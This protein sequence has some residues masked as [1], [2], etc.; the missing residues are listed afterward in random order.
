MSNTYLEYVNT[1][2][3]DKNF[4]VEF[5]D[6]ANRPDFGKVVARNK[7]AV[8]EIG[9]SGTNW[10]SPSDY[11]PHDTEKFVQLENI[12]AARLYFDYDKNLFPALALSLAGDVKELKRKFD[13]RQIN[14]EELL[15]LSVLLNETLS[16]LDVFNNR[17][18]LDAYFN[19]VKQIAEL[20]KPQS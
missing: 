12:E 10:C 19:G 2:N 4:I 20:R 11:K 1:K 13:S 6:Y 8:Y 5:T 16:V 15:G 3:Q 17:S 7:D 9:F 14:D 18:S